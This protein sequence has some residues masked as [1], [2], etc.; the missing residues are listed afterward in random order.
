MSVKKRLTGWIVLL[1]MSAVV[2]ISGPLGVWAKSQVAAQPM[3]TLKPIEVEMY[4]DYFKPKVITIS[5]T[6]TTFLLKNKGK[7]E[8]TFTVEALGVDVEVH[9]GEEKTITVK[10]DK[11]GTYELICRYHLKQGMVGQVIVKNN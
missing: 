4:D 9:P 2:T 8:H 1:V 3:E 10:P 6:P 11:P 7:K 5:N